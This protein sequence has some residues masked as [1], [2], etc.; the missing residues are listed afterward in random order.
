M[1]NICVL[2]CLAF[3]FSCSPLPFGENVPAGWVVGWGRNLSGQATGIPDGMYSTGLVTIAD[4]VLTNAVVLSAG[5]NHSLAIK[6][7]GTV[8]GWGYNKFDQ[9]MGDDTHKANKLVIVDGQILNNVS[10]VSA[11]QY[12]LA[13][14]SNGAAVVWGRDL[15]GKPIV[16]PDDFSNALSVA[17]GQSYSLAIRKNGTI[18]TAACSEMKVKLITMTNLVAVDTAVDN[19]VQHNLGLKKDG[20]VVVWN[21]NN[22]ILDTCPGL[23]NVVAVA[24]GADHSLALKSDGTVV[25]WGWA[26]NTET[27]VPIGLTNVVAIAASKTD[28]MGYNGFS[29]ALKSDGTVVSWGKF[30]NQR[31]VNVPVG[32]SNVVAIAAGA[33]FCLAI[34]TNRAVA[35]RF[36]H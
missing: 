9:T 3:L 19:F 15:S 34:T 26:S 31:P 22:G 6:S 2:V 8:V 28:I 36:R 17:A 20:T 12:S 14:Q 18:T 13:L 1:K 10:A 16:I 33:D 32:L 24:A 29:L 11:F 35:E 7:D 23:S 25:E 5:V 4:Q 21:N 30:S 27:N